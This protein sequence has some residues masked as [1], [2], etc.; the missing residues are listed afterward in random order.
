M[1]GTSMAT[2]LTAGAVAALRQHLRRDRGVADPTAALLKAVLVAGVRRLPGTAPDGAVLDPHQGFGRVDLAA[3]VSPPDGVSLRLEPEGRLG[4]G[5]S[6]HTEF[7]VDDGSEPLRVVLAYSDY[8]GAR[9]VNNLNLVVKAPDG[10]VRVGNQAEGAQPA[11][12]TVNNVELVQVTAPATGTW[13]VDVIG[14][15]VP[16]GPQPFAL[17]VRG[18][19]A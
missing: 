17:V 10:T 3:A 8:P 2:P 12:D 6:W 16:R 19:L 15:N 5:Q 13:S 1:G 4:T 11:F 9:L 7:T 14:S 18:H